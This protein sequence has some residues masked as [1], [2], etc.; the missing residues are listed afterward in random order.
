[1][2][3]KHRV[4]FNEYGLLQGGQ[5]KT[6]YLPL[7]SGILHA[8]AL[9]HPELRDHYEF[10]PYF[11]H[12]DLPERI[13]GAYERP[14]VAAF[15]M[16]IWNA[17]LCLFVAQEVKRRWPECLIVFGGAHVPH[18]SE[19][20]LEE[21]PFIDVAVRAEGEETFV[22]L[23]QRFRTSASFEGIR[24]ATWRAPDGAIRAEAD[25]PFD[26]DMDRYPS[27]Y[28]A[29]LFE[30]S[31]E[32]HP[33]L[34][35]QAII[36]TNRGCPFK[37]TFCYWGKGGLNHKFK[38]RALD[39]LAAEIDWMA[40]HGIRYILSADS[41]FGMHARDR[42]IAEY[43]I[44]AN[45][46]YGYPERFR[47]TYGKNTDDR[48]FEVASMLSRAGLD[49]GVS[50]TH[51]SLSPTVQDNIKRWNIKLGAY[52]RLQKRFN[53]AGIATHSDLIIGLPGETFDSLK[54]GIQTLLD[55]GAVH[56]NIYFLEVY[57]NTDM[58]N[59]DYQKEFAIRAVRT[60]LQEN[61]CD[62]RKP[63]EVRE[64]VEVVVEN[65]SMSGE[66]WKRMWCMAFVSMLF[67]SLKM[68][69]FL[70]H[71]LRDRFGI[72][73]TDLF[74]FI[75]ETKMS[76]DTGAIARNEIARYRNALSGILEGRG[77]G[78]V[79]PEFGSVYWRVEEASFLRLSEQ[80][81]GFYAE[82]SDI[83]E[84]LLESRGMDYDRD[85][86]RELVRYQRLRMPS[87]Q[88]LAETSID[89]AYNVPEYC[90]RLVG[91][92]PIPLEK[93]AQTLQ[94]ES[95]D[96]REDRTAFANERVLYARKNESTMNRVWWRPAEGP[97]RQSP[98]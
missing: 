75:S 57:P 1:M 21:N 15:S 6:A 12:R 79:E 35:F 48:L 11:F 39:L 50:L 3:T 59:P 58:A 41:N 37:C 22:E 70:I 89:F 80:L 64:F 97:P 93:K 5:G 98:H 46:K 23:L 38:F 18:A 77:I 30:E 67:H 44:E 96:Y 91:G 45:R 81:D 87:T 51:Q 13:L 54:E 66:E 92:D 71:Y 69:Y 61:H 8:Y 53:D 60:E 43:L 85:E 26:A 20:F 84:Q 47:A 27:P 29:G 33:E 31:I 88:S 42:D 82:M 68:G 32:K 55:R 7:A 52:E 9:E 17:Q 49:K 34:E 25:R 72:P 95:T 14:A 36:E 83:V 76:G 56:L 78:A 90:E 10:A 4:Y 65:S 94:V 86:L 24:G 28:L 74:S 16:Y 73:F 63:S 40:R 2:T 62:V 19:A